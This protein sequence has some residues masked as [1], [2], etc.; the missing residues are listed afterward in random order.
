MKR[1]NCPD[2]GAG[3]GEKYLDDCDVE[4]CTV[5]K[6][7]RLQ[8]NCENHDKELAKWTGKWPGDV[9]D[10]W[11]E[12]GWPSEKDFQH[13]GLCANIGIIDTRG[14]V[15]AAGWPVGVIRFCICP[16][17]RALKRMHKG[18]ISDQE[19]EELLKSK[20]KIYYR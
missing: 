15:T 20:S 19:I 9:G 18:D 10:L 14:A 16:N 3:I 12:F 6:G 17:G 2:C 5:C 13:C 1:D 4:E 11:L 7:Q 8:C